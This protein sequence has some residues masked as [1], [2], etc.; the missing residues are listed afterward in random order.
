MKVG[1][2]GPSSQ[3]SCRAQPCACAAASACHAMPRWLPPMH[4]PSELKERYTSDERA[5]LG[6]GLGLGSGLGLG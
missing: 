1:G 6:L 4:S 3:L 5:W 2:G